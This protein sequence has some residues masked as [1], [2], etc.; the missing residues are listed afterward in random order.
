MRQDTNDT[1]RKNTY[2]KNTYLLKVADGCST[3]EGT[4]QGV[5][6]ATKLPVSATKPRRGPCHTICHLPAVRSEYSVVIFTPEYIHTWKY[7]AGLLYE[8]V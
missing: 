1:S 8:H 6:I 3:D 5:S 4:R 7:S 2:Y